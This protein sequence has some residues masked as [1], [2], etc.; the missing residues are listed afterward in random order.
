MQKKP[1]HLF[2]LHGVLE[3]NESMFLKKGTKL[4]SI[5]KSKCPKCHEG[6]FFLEKG[7]FR[8]KNITKIH[9]TCPKCNLKYMMEPSFFYGAMYV[10]YGVS[11]GMSILTFLITNLIFNFE[12]LASF[13]AIVILLIACTPFSLRL[14]RLI[15]INI[16]VAYKEKNN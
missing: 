10:A 13:L 15:W 12:L 8:L 5:L 3:N 16:F 2:E 4:F 1:I 7:S 6:D 11:V 14:S 9:D